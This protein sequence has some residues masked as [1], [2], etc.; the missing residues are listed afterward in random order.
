MLN[1]DLQKERGLLKLP[2]LNAPKTTPKALFFESGRNMYFP[3]GIRWS[4]S[5]AHVNS[6]GEEWHRNRELK[7][8]RKPL[9][10]I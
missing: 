8:G 9:E 6:G 10:M 4:E 5:P 2:T 1:E 3:I 7:S